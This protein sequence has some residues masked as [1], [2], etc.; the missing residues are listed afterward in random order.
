MEVVGVVDLLQ[1]VIVVAVIGAADVV[2]IARYAKAVVAEAT[3][4]TVAIDCC[5]K[6]EL[7][8]VVAR[9]QQAMLLSLM[10]I[11]AAVV[12]AISHCWS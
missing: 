7:L 6:L 1:P 4:V 11:I 5:L 8:H 10:L 9:S 2:T 3:A 12:A